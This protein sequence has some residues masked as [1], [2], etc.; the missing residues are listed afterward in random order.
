MIEFHCSRYK[1]D[2]TPIVTDQAVQEYAEAVLN[3]YK[4]KLL[5]EPGKV[6]ATHFLESYLGA[7]VD[8]Q[9]IYYDEDDNPIAGGTVFNSGSILIF[10]REKMCVRPIEVTAGTILIDNSTMEEGKEGFAKF[11][12]LHEGGHFLM[13]PTVYRK[14]ENQL[15]LFDFGMENPL[16]QKSHVVT[17]KRSS[18]CGQGERKLVTE[19]DFREHQANIFAAAVAMPRPTFI[20]CAR[21]MIRKSGFSDGVWVQDD[22]LDWDYELGLTYLIERLAETF[23]VSRSAAKVQLKRQRL[24]LTQEEY[25]QL[26]PQLAVAF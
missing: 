23:G 22:V 10:D 16:D 18:I 6:N 4:P 25:R 2:G 1:K 13:H 26:H 9:D 24:L 3:D 11:T 8:Y 21:E 12:H 17:C 14:N 19:E 15:T 5:K 20:P 7:T